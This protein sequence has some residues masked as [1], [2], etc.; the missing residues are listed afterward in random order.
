M[1]LFAGTSGSDVEN[2]AVLLRFAFL[3]DAIDPG[4]RT[5]AICALGLKWSDEKLGDFCRVGAKRVFRAQQSSLQPGKHLAA[6]RCCFGLQVRDNDDFKLQA[7]GLVDGHQLHTAAGV[8]GRVRQRGELVEGRVE[9][10][11][12]KILLAGR[13]PVEAAPQQIN[14]G[15]RCGVHAVCAAEA[16]PELFETGAY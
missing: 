6:T 10:G 8:G 9:R 11:S 2:A 5:A 12:E 14:I 7:F 1:E 15:A 3:V 16:K 13:E 4:F